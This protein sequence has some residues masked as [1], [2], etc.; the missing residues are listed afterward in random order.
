[1]GKGKLSSRIEKSINLLED[2]EIKD[3]SEMMDDKMI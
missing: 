3:I 1:M 2:V